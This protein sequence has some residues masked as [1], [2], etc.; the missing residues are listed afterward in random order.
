MRRAALALAAAALANGLTQKPSAGVNLHE[1]EN[2]TKPGLP[3]PHS[4][5][6]PVVV[7]I[8]GLEGSG[9]T[10][11]EG[12]AGRI[13]EGSTVMKS[14]L[15]FPKDWECGTVWDEHGIGEMVSK[16][17]QLQNGAVYV[18]P[19]ATYPQCG[20]AD[21]KNKKLKLDHAKRRDKYHPRLDWIKQAADHADVEFR[22]ILLYRPLEDVLASNC[23]HSFSEP[24]QGES[25]TLKKNAFFLVGH[26]RQLDAGTIQCFKYGHVDKMQTAL[27][28]TFGQAGGY[29]ELVKKVW[30]DRGDEEQK[31]HQDIRHL[32]PGWQA[33]LKDMSMA[34]SALRG[35]CQSVGRVGIRGLASFA[36]R[37]G[38]GRYVPSS[39][40]VQEEQE[41]TKELEE[42]QPA[43]ELKEEQPAEN[44]M[45]P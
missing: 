18:L 3:G 21:P 30:T 42:E 33:M 44:A 25:Q 40:E 29:T 37:F 1:F 28:Q 35:I 23:L 45:G 22:T 32:V 15:S 31:E 12:I 13:I 2:S 4:D 19:R 16:M 34:D 9:H 17:R 5:K 20:L 7:F 43:E 39:E 36:K 8:A 11:I 6:K 27:Q 14:V 10:L 24:C 26:L 41:M 38:A